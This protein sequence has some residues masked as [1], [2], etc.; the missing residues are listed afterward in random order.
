LDVVVCH[1]LFQP[2]IVFMPL[3]AC[4]AVA[5][6]WQGRHG[7]RYVNTNGQPFDTLRPGGTIRITGWKSPWH[8]NNVNNNVNGAPRVFTGG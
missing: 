4:V 8:T 1:G 5:A 6:P 3:T 7:M 2:V